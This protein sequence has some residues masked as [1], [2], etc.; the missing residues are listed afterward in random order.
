MYNQILASQ[1]LSAFINLLIQSKEY[2]ILFGSLVVPYR[3]FPT[4]PAAN[5]PNTDRLYENL[6]KQNNSII[7]PSFS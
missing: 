5:F 2:D 1:G 6:T 7:V 4:L 3:R